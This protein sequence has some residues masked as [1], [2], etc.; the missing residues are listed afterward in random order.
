MRRLTVAAA[1]AAAVLAGTASAQ[2]AG[3][4]AIGAP[5]PLELAQK[6]LA[7]AQAE[8]KK[9]NWSMAVAIVE[10]NGSLVAFQKMDG[11][12]YGSINVAMDKANS[13]ALYRRP[14]AAFHNALKA[15][16]TYV[17]QLRGANAVP[18]G[19]PIVVGGKLVGGI[20]SSGGTGEQDTQISEAG[21]TAVK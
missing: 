2:Q 15:G 9:N 20:G 1:L 12:Q 3:P 18:G 7:A 5:I 11:T 8:A 10:P 16:N 17:M 14:T 21:L 6:I 13:A 4:P 19:L